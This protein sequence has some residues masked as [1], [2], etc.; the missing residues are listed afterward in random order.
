MTSDDDKLP[1]RSSRTDIDRFI[2]RVSQL[3]AQ[4]GGT[5]GGR[6][7]FA[8]DATASR[9]AAWDQACQLQAE[10]FTE[11]AAL[12]GLQAQLVFY[13]GYGEFSAG[14][15]CA[16]TH[17]FLQAMTGV[18]CR[19]G[20]T[21]I[22]RVLQHALTE[23]RRQ[24]VNA[25]VFIGD[26][27]EEPVDSLCRLAGE[28]GLLGVPVFIFHEGHDVIAARSFQEIAR[29][30]R[31]ACCPFDTASA[32]QLRALLGAVAVYAAGGRRALES[33]SQRRNPAVQKL[34]RQLDICD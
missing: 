31:G 8:L 5:T 22:G 29:L 7:I 25:L 27:M 2:K 15:W 32:A 1:Q 6:L 11:T 16:D 26:C 20:R 4:P 13:R 10:M 33:Y 34:L 14:Q 18:F 3:P 30:S 19:G 9:E 28:L 23:H 12:G 24:R 21:Q 17:R